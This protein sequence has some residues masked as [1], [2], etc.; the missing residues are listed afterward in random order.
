VFVIV[1]DLAGVRVQRDESDLRIAE[2]LFGLAFARAVQFA[3]KLIDALHAHLDG[4][5]S[6]ALQVGV[7]RG[8][9]AQVLMREVLIADALHKLVVDEID[10]VGG[11]AG[12]DV[13]RCQVE[14]L[15]L[16]DGRFFLG[17]GPGL[18]H[19][20]EY[21]IAPRHRALGMAVWVQAAGALDHTRE[22]RTL[23]GVELAQV[24]AEIGLGG[25]AEAVDRIAAAM[26]QVDLVG[27]HGKDL[28]LAEVGLKLEGHKD[29]AHLVFDV[30]KFT[31]A[32]G[33]D[34]EVLG[35]LHGEGR[36]AAAK[37]AVADGVVPR[38]AHHAVVIDAAVLEETAIFNGGDGL[39]HAWRDVVVADHAALGTVRVF[40]ER[41]DE[42][43]LQLVAAERGAVLRRNAGDD[44]SGGPDGGAVGRVI[45]LGAGLDEDAVAGQVVG[46]ELRVDVVAGAA[47]VDGDGVGCQLLA[48]ADLLGRGVNLRDVGKDVAGGEPGVQGMFVMEV[49]VSEQRDTYDGAAQQQD[50]ERAQDTVSEGCVRCTTG[51]AAVFELDY[52]NLLYL[53]G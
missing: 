23:G 51:A 33:L 13:G 1:K 15:G 25:L 24:F 32:V 10:E 12:V 40:R 17:N 44:A 11:L 16:G 14:G 8:V 39:Y 45:A 7:E 3:D 37:S 49:E 35:Q 26:P 52:Q 41:R 53:D 46:A 30:L 48:V 6:G 9:D 36:A 22:Q 29:L 28:L 21:D 47:Q 18:D 2:R 4:L 38:P 50:K 34:E 20:V 19:R 31:G 27:V 5:G 43:R 42:L